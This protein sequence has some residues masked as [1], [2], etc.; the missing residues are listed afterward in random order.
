M[1]QFIGS[2]VPTATTT[3]LTRR[4]NS[5]APLVEA[6]D[7]FAERALLRM[8]NDPAAVFEFFRYDGMERTSSQL[9][10]NTIGIV[11]ILDDDAPPLHQT[12]PD[13]RLFQKVAGYLHERT[14]TSNVHGRFEWH[15]VSR[16]ENEA[17]RF[18]SDASSCVNA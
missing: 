12:D 14:C 2:S 9:D 3:A 13:E 16:L 6:V 5:S 8:L 11:S 1:V 10:S 7:S 17:C 4:F 15:V 18:N